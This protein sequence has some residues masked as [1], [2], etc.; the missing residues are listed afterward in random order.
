M[1]E[2]APFEIIK[3]LVK[4]NAD[5]D[6]QSVVSSQYFAT[7]YSVGKHGFVCLYNEL[8]EAEKL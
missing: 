1:A 8:L 5:I 2:K 3:M 7:A 6:H 4:E